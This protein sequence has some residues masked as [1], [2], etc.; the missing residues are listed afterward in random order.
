M[1]IS[2]DAG[3]GAA[4]GPPSV[5]FGAPACVST[6][7]RGDA[8]TPVDVV[9]VLLSVELTVPFV[10]VGAFTSVAFGSLRGVIVS[11]F[12]V[13]RRALP[14]VLL[15]TG[16][17]AIGFSAAPAFVSTFLRGVVATVGVP[18]GVVA[19]RCACTGFVALASLSRAVVVVL[20]PPVIIPSAP[21]FSP[22]D[23]VGALPSARRV[24]P[25]VEGAGSWGVLL[26][27]FCRVSLSRMPIGCSLLRR[28]VAPVLL[29]GGSLRRSF[30]YVQCCSSR[31]G[32]TVAGGSL[33]ISP[34]NGRSIPPPRLS[35][36]VTGFSGTRRGV[37][38]VAGGYCDE[39]VGG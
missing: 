39:A 2:P 32:I 18:A 23:A 16:A 35:S 15:A 34:S 20:L 19:P 26:A 25:V 27:W 12:S 17:D 29:A 3:V 4:S 1:I 22:R 5:G 8:L 24:A 13:C 31:S 38:L 7:R 9:P 6:S 30:S 21:L 28:G 10:A 33:P 14:L 11:F 36:R 37:L